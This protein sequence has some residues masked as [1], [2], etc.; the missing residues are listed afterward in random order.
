VPLTTGGVP[1]AVGWTRPEGAAPA[2]A[3]AAVVEGGDVVFSAIEDTLQIT[4]IAR[5][6]APEAVLD[7][8]LAPPLALLRGEAVDAEGCAPG[9][10]ELRIARPSAEPI[11]VPLPA[12]AVSAAVR[13][14]ERGLLALWMAPLG[15]RAPRRV[16]Y[17]AV[18]GDDGALV[19]P[20]IPVG[21]ASAFA[22]AASG[23]NVDV[24]LEDDGA[25]L[26]AAATCAAP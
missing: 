17:A 2:A 24:W 11:V 5:I 26:R 15:C 22:V 9:P 14:L 19:A 4:E 6:P 8:S 13:R 10:A 20:P 16:V 7:V 12:P 21:Y 25:I 23:A 18:L 1:F 3:R